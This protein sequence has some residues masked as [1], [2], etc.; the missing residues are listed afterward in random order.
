MT[1]LQREPSSEDTSRLSAF[2]RNG[3][4]HF[5]GVRAAP[6]ASKTALSGDGRWANA[7]QVKPFALPRDQYVQRTENGSSACASQ[8][9]WL[10]TTCS[11]AAQTRLPAGSSRSGWA[12]TA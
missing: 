12:T 6:V 8:A 3:D 11:N 7:G 2:R 1:A 4:G 9:T 5:L 10:S